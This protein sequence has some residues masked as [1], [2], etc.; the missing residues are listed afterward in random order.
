MHINDGRT[1]DTRSACSHQQSSSGAPDGGRTLGLTGRVF[2]CWLLSQAGCEPGASAQLIP[3]ETSD[4]GACLEET[5]AVQCIGADAWHCVNGHQTL[6]ARCGALPCAT[7][8]GCVTCVPRDTTCDTAGRPQTC[9]AAGTGYTAGEACPTG[10]SCAAGRCV[11]LCAQARAD[12]SYVGCDYWAVATLNSALG[13]LSSVPGRPTSEVGAVGVDGFQFAVVVANSAA[14][15][16]TLRV[17]GGGLDAAIVQTVAPHQLATVALPWVASTSHVVAAGSRTTQPLQSVQAPGAAYHITSSIPVVIYQFNPLSFRDSRRATCAKDDLTCYS[18]TNDASL[19]L[20]AHVLTGN[21]LTVAWG[22][23]TQAEGR[24]LVGLTPG[25]L[26][27]VG[28]ASTPT[29]VSVLLSSHTIAGNGLPAG[30][31]GTT[32]T[33]TLAAGEV[34]Q[35]LGNGM[36]VNSASCVRE[37]LYRDRTAEVCAP[38]ATFD[39]TGTVVRSDQPVAVFAGHDCARVPYNRAA[40]DHLE[41]QLFPSESLGTHYVVAATEP[42]LPGREPNILRIVSN[43]PHNTLTFTP[44]YN[45]GG[46]PVVLERGQ[47]IDLLLE[48]G[49]EIQGSGSLSVTSYLVGQNY[50]SNDDESAAGVADD[51]S[52]VLEVPVEQWRYTYDFLTPG[53][54]TRSYVNLVA[55]RG[56]TLSLDGAVVSTGSPGVT[57][58]EAGE[59]FVAWR[60]DVS[61]HPGAHHVES[62]RRQRFSAKVYGFGSY[63]SYMYPGGLDLTHIS[64]PG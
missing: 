59:G 49:V 1:S 6:V 12:N 2:M 43:A 42:Q 23:Q 15:S 54:Y 39:L 50:F 30:S 33:R 41:E 3:A 13:G 58:F 52:M 46:S 47:F 11:D 16:A 36:D 19:L 37:R 20:P 22:T 40:C 48:D 27:I 38:R 4:G 14:T 26:T 62:D 56:A 21:Y 61:A 45:P 63:T 53:T 44:A 35:I 32:L 17:T 60:V 8:I 51:P 10:L 57:S 5:G 34:W 55:P 18:F 29:T 9:N 7:G 64:P 24:N 28:T 31:P 25:F